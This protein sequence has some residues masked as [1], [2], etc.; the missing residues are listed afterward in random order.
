[1]IKFILNLSNNTVIT[2]ISVEHGRIDNISGMIKQNSEGKPSHVM[3]CCTR[4]E[5]AYVLDRVLQ[6]IKNLEGCANLSSK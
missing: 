3:T 6:R 2:F 5:I 1:M 4:S